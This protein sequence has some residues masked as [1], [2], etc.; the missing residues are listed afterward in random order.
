MKLFSSLIFVNAAQAQIVP[1]DMCVRDGRV[2][3][4]EQ[5]DELPVE[6]ETQ[7]G[8]MDQ[9]RRY[10]DLKMMAE[11]YW[12]K[13]GGGAFDERKYWA[14]GCHCYLLGDRPMSEMGLGSPVDALDNRCKAYKDCQKCA[15]AKHGNDCI[16]EMVKYTWRYS[17][18]TESLAAREDPG[19]CARDLF[20][21]DRQ[22]IFDVWAKREIFDNKFHA[23]WSNDDPELAFD[24]RNP[25]N[26]PRKGGV[27]VEHQCCGG[28]DRPFLWLNL[29]KNRCCATRNQETGDS[30]AFDAD[31]E[32]GEWLGF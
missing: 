18:K 6:N 15:R 27:R 14:Y 30:A 28:Y 7:L 20:E 8:R 25:D 2:A 5:I 23:F 29:N 10:V 21:C 19:T 3:P 22:L 31:C 13:N 9:E 1:D 32:H 24:N 17:K 4:C 26:C 16:G 12:A 11:K